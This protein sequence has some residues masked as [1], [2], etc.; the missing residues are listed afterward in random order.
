MADIFM[1]EIIDA[2]DI[3]KD[4]FLTTHRNASNVIFT[5]PDDAIIT[6]VI[7][8]VNM[9]FP[10][11]DVKQ[12]KIY[13][14]KI[15]NCHRPYEDGGKVPNP[16]TSKDMD[17]CK[18]VPASKV[19]TCAFKIYIEQ[20]PAGII[21]FIKRVQKVDKSEYQ[22]IAIIHDRDTKIDMNDLYADSTLKPHIH[23]I[24]RCVKSS[25]R[26]SQIMSMLGIVF[27]PK[28]DDTLLVRNKGIDY[29]HKNFATATAYLTHETE[30]AEK[31]KAPYAMHELISNLTFDEIQTIKDG[32]IRISSAS[33]RVDKQHM[34]ELDEYAFK[35][36]FE[37]KDFDDWYNTLTFA[38]RTSASMRT[39]R[40]SYMRGCQKKFD[41]HATVLRKCIFI[42]GEPN[43]GKT[44]ASEKA[45]ADKKFLKVSGGGTG[46]FDNLKPSHSAIIIDDDIC[47]NLLNM[48]DNY[49]CK[50]Y[51]RQKDNPIWAG[52]WLVVT[53]NL[54]FD[55]WLNTCGIHEQVHINAM[56][57]RFFVCELVEQNGVSH[58][59]LQSPSLRGSVAERQQRLLDFLKFQKAFDETIKDY[60]PATNDEFDYAL[61]IDDAFIKP[62][63]DL[64]LRKER[65]LSKIN[66]NMKN[67]SVTKGVQNYENSTG[68]TG[69]DSEAERG[70]YC[71]AKEVKE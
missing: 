62:F 29:I 50:A 14:H 49:L 7:S 17:S 21:D 63:S 18:L 19:R 4:A 40:E 15:I 35:R 51:K 43:T 53:S 45:L 25:K 28:I 6:D 1:P 34:A 27:R 31:Y 60:C 57:S 24:V 39:V 10:D 33:Y 12:R 54:E 70:L 16:L 66:E 69:T 26:I 61:Y 11:A 68:V 55:D 48:S 30:E 13:I 37:L 46:K 64:A 20:L 52:E 32:Y 5:Y 36:G 56:R 23:I 3:K 8:K 67:N 2:E 22:V 47:P 38:E 44:Y 9:A 59:G 58:L 65:A 71:I 41:E 42:K